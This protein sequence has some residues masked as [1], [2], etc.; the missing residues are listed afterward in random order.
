MLC[1][2]LFRIRGSVFRPGRFCIGRGFV[3]ISEGTRPHGIHI[4]TIVS[5]I[6][7][8]VAAVVE[9]PKQIVDPVAEEVRMPKLYI[10][11]SLESA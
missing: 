7:M 8:V 6:V 10:Y 4:G 5:M 2:T 3:I 1:S 9:M 11:I